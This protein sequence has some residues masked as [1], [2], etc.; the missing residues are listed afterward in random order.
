MNNKPTGLLLGLALSAALLAMAPTAQ[1]HDC[2]SSNS[3]CNQPCDGNE[4]HNHEWRDFGVL[5]NYC[6]SDPA[7]PP[8]PPPSGGGCSF[9]ELATSSS[10][11]LNGYEVLGATI[12][13][14]PVEETALM[15]DITCSSWRFA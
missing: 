13:D 11:V 2:Y 10:S 1:A 4:E 14:Q 9:G 7:P 8:P 3:N 6:R 15:L 5:Y 12:A